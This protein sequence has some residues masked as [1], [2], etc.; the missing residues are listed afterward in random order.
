MPAVE[1]RFAAWMIS[2]VVLAVGALF[3]AY[4]WIGYIGSDDVAW[5]Y[6]GARGWID[7]FPYVGGHG[8]IRTPLTIPMALAVVAL[9]LGIAALVLPGLVYG[10]VMVGALGVWLGR[11]VSPAVGLAAGLAIVT[12]PLVAVQASIANIDIVEGSAV[13]LAVVLLAAAVRGRPSVELFFGAGVLLGIAFLARETAVF[14]VVAV[15]AAFI[16]G[17]GVARWRY[18]LSGAGFLAVW[19]VELVYLAIMTGDPLYRLA[20]ARNHDPSQSRAANLEGNLLVHPA[21]DPL[22]VLLVNQEFAL[23]FWISIPLGI[24]LC[25]G[26]ALAP[27]ERRIARL[28]ALFGLVWALGVAALDGALVLNPR[29]FLV[30]AL[31]AAVLVGWSLVVLWRRGRHRLVAVLGL[32]LLAGNIAGTA[33]ENRDFSFGE[34]ALRDL[35][36]ARPG[37]II[38]TDHETWRRAETLLAFEGLDRRIEPEAP[39]AGRLY[40]V[41]RPRVAALTPE[42]AQRCFGAFA[43]WERIAEAVPER[44][45]PFGILA[46]LGVDRLM[47]E[48]WWRRL[49]TPHEGVVLYRVTATGSDRACTI[50][51]RPVRAR[52]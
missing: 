48:R 52:P 14:A 11:A 23:L 10:A 36:R 32:G 8:T 28:F 13:M 2:P 20:L 50:G 37:E 12:M 7:S 41:N 30:S 19:L 42:M 1:A 43:S 39:V 51:D 6:A 9:G 16:I 47:P 40:L 4:G 18:F 34:F 3:V 17:F 24:W 38:A 45:F 15:I 33:I 26:T 27:S 21:L 44:R 31:V 5:Y 25:V 49:A 35:A 29:Y 46:A 22:V